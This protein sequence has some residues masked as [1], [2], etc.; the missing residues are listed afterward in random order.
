M[1]DR[2]VIT[3]VWFSTPTHIGDEDHPH[4]ESR[5]VRVA[6]VEGEDYAGAVSARTRCGRTG[7]AG[8]RTLRPDRSRGILP[9]EGWLHP[10][11]QA[12]LPDV[13]RPRGLPRVRL[14][15]RRA[16]RHLGRALRARAPQ[17][18]E[19]RRLRYAG[20]IRGRSGAT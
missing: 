2:H 7:L 14:D 13:R 11:G 4:T 6:R 20:V 12:R 18:Q 3:S 5:S 1:C 10:G 17:A 9:G 8:E 16:L 19:A 15:E